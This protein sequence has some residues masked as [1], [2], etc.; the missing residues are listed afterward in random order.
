MSELRK[1]KLH[2]VWKF[3]HY[4]VCLSGSICAGIYAGGTRWAESQL[5]IEVPVWGIAVI[6][7]IALWLGFV[8]ARWAWFD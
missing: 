1:V 7:Q 4:R 5:G 3:R 6:S 2:R 8:C